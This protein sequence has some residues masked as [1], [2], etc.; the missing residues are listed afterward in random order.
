MAT[1]SVADAPLDVALVVALA[2]PLSSVRATDAVMAAGLCAAVGVFVTAVVNTGVDCAW[3]SDVTGGVAFIDGDF[4][5]GET[6]VTF[7]GVVGG[8]TGGAEHATGEITAIGT[9]IATSDAGVTDVVDDAAFGVGEA[10][11]RTLISVQRLLYRRYISIA[12]K[13]VVAGA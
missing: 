9:D 1:V 10:T 8:A 7:A 12:P 3:L 4:T 13:E 11:P 5:S 6:E 2:F